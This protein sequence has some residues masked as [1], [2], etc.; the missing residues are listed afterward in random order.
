M[1]QLSTISF[2]T[3]DVQRDLFARLEQLG[4][5][6]TI[7]D[8]PAHKTVEEGKVLRGQMAGTF[9]KNLLLKDKKSRY[10]LLSVHEDRVLDLKT[11]PAQL[12]AKG[13]LSFASAERMVEMLG[14]APGALTP[15]GLLNDD[16]GNV[17]AVIDASLMS[18]DQLN[19]HPLIQTKSMGLRPDELVAFVRSCGRE[20]MIVDLDRS[21]SA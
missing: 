11:L 3:N 2:D 9:T 18:H 5:A 4:I 16:G 1:N 21:G 20:P 15:M 7:V 17:V 14:V 6:T 13:H 10:Y 8:Y 19:F 12:G